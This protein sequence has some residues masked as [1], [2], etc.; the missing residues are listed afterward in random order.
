MNIE[1]VKKELQYR[2]ARS[3]GKGGQNV[4][5]VET[6]VEVLLDITASLAFTDDDKILIFSKLEN[7]IS[8]EGILQVTNQTER[9][10]LA[11][12]LLAEKKLFRMLEKALKKEK[13]RKVTSTPPSVLAM[14]EG[15]KRHNADKKAQR[16]KVR[17][18][19]SGFDLSFF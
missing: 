16:K 11:N 12:K 8:K 13:P 15:E 14:R 6:K 18:N 19:D 3:G 1:N 9:S 7:N 5:K 17:I 4:N 10:Q 2:T